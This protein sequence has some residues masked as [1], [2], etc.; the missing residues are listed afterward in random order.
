LYSWITGLNQDAAKNSST[1]SNYNLQAYQAEQAA[2][3]A[4]LGNIMNA[5]GQIGGA[6]MTG[7]ASLAGNKLLASALTSKAGA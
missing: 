6:A 7:G 3:N 2:K 5:V 1:V 4:M